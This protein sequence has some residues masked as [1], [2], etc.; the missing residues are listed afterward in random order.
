MARF[1]IE[2]SDDYIRERANADNVAQQAKNGENPLGLMADLMVF[3][4]LER[5]IDKGNN[6]FTIS[7]NNIK[8][9]ALKLFNNTT[10]YAGALAVIHSEKVEKPT[11]EC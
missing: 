2:V 4:A 5:E 11:T 8:P 10:T 3:T 6:E 7:S 9:D 1:I